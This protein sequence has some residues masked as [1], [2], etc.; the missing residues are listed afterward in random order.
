MPPFAVTVSGIPIADSEC[1]H[2][3]V[4]S[5]CLRLGCDRCPVS[6]AE[7]VA[8]GPMQV[9]QGVHVDGAHTVV[10]VQAGVLKRYRMAFTERAPDDGSG[11]DGS[12]HCG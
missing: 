2:P 4:I 3:E 6:A 12:G 7:G 1:A 11:A 10:S 9:L 8:T 5:K